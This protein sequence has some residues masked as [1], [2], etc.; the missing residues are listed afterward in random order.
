MLVQKSVDMKVAAREVCVH[1]DVCTRQ[2][3]IL[4]VVDHGSTQEAM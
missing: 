1:F 3:Y 2:M 4:A